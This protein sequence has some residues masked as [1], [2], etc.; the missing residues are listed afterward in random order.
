MESVLHRCVSLS[1][2]KDHFLDLL[3]IMY[4][5][6][7]PLYKSCHQFIKREKKHPVYVN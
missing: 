1:Y 5:P 7:H 2:V 3:A 6:I 4:L